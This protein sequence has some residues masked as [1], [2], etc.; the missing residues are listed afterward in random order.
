MRLNFLLMLA[1]IA[2]ALTL[3]QMQYES[4][5]LFVELD[6]ARAEG[7]KLQAEKNNLLAEKNT[8]ST[9]LRVE[10]L[11]KNQL[12]M[13]PTSPAVTEYVKTPANVAAKGQP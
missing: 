10:Q 4:R 13:R 6:Q 11:A 9:N 3:V 2:S 7:R 5:R 1:V 12:K 8:Q